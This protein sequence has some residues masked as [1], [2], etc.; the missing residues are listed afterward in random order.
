MNTDPAPVCDFARSFVRW[1]SD[2]L[3]KPMLTVSQ[4]PA[5]SNA[6]AANAVGISLFIQANLLPRMAECKGAARRGAQETDRDSPDRSVLQPGRR[7]A[8]LTTQA[9]H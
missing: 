5:P 7:R 2:T 9:N 4:P 8:A 1:R 3:K 6:A